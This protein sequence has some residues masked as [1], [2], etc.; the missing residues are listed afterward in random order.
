[1]TE[2]ANEEFL[3]CISGDT[4][5]DISSVSSV[6]S[7]AGAL[8]RGFIDA[9]GLFNQGSSKPKTTH[10]NDKR[11]AFRTVAVQRVE[12]TILGIQL[13]TNGLQPDHINIMTYL[14]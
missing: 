7:Y 9:V 3:A 8:R 1:M 6:K 10:L 5:G 2:Q 4:G 12:L 13:L 11:Y 14:R